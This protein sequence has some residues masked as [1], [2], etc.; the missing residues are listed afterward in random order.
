MAAQIEYFSQ[1]YNVIIADNRGHG[2]SGLGN[3]P[4]TYEKIN[5]DL[6]ALLDHLKIKKT[7]IIGWSDGAVVGLHIAS[8]YP[9]RVNKLVSFAANLFAGEPAIYPWLDRAL[10]HNGATIQDGLKKN[11]NDTELQHQK[12]IYDLMMNMTPITPIMLQQ[13]TAPTLVMAGDSDA[14]TN[15]HTVD[16]F[17]HIPNAHLAIMPG[18]T[19]F[20]PMINPEVFNNITAAF[21]ITPYKRPT[22]ME[23]L[24]IY[25]GFE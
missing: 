1:S 9:T 4:L 17:E 13:I 23:D 22:T 7:N 11:P 10:R 25:F 5:S 24:K 16:I 19:H 6:I 14:I 18:Q 8:K 15:H 2:K 3:Q 20:M 12:Q 21:L